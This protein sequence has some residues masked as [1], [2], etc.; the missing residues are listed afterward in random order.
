VGDEGLRVSAAA[1]NIDEA[2]LLADGISMTALG[3]KGALTALVLLAAQV[4]RQH[5]EIERLKAWRDTVDDMLTVC[6]MVASDDPRESIN[7]LI[8][9]HCSV[10]LDP[11]VSSDAAALV[12]AERNRCATIARNGCLVPPDGGSPTEDERLLCEEIERR[13]RAEAA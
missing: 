9:W 12:A 2:L 7:R 13:I 4:R 10:A 1:M 11:A 6:H 8:N 3:G 5:A